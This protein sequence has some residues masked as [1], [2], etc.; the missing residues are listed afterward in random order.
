MLRTRAGYRFH[1]DVASLLCCF[2]ASLLRCFA[3]LLLADGRQLFALAVVTLST[4]TPPCPHVARNPRAYPG[5]SVWPNLTKRLSRA[6]IT[7]VLC[8][9][10]DDL[11]ALATLFWL[12]PP[13]YPKATLLPFLL[14]ASEMRASPCS[15]ASPKPATT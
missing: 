5:S 11:Q 2:A 7:A 6:I 9:A 13:T 1:V 3:T 14:V 10:P 12:L 8:L 15:S 4:Q